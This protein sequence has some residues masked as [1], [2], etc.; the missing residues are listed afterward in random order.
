MR[1]RPLLHLEVPLAPTGVLERFQQRLAEEGTPCAGHVGQRELSLIVCERERHLFSPYISLEVREQE[2][3]GAV[4]RGRFGPHPTLWTGFMLIYSALLFGIL[5]SASY[6]F[7]Q[8]TLDMPP[9]GLALAGALSA[10]ELAACGVDLTGRRV[11]EP[12]MAGMRRFVCETLDA[13]V[14]ASV[15]VQPES[16]STPA[17]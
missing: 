1:Q 4:V 6:G 5:I 15:P 2:G 17:A 14:E 9:W 8:W 12:Q 3:V 16:Q 11:G 10:I 7:V 13:S